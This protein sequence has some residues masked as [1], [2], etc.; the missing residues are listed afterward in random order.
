[1]GFLMSEKEE[2]VHRVL[3]DAINEGVILLTREGKV[4]FCN[5]L[6]A[7]MV[8]TPSDEIINSDFKQFFPT[9][10]HMV[11]EE[12]LN[13][14]K[15]VGNKEQFTLLPHDGS[16]LA[17]ELSI[18]SIAIDYEETFF[19]VITDLAER[20]KQE[21]ALWESERRFRLL[22]D[23]AKDYA[24]I[25]LDADGR[26][27]HWN[28]GA[29]RLNGYTAD[30]ML[31]ESFERFYLPEDIELEI[32][33]MALE[34]AR[35][36]GRY[37]CEG[38]RVRKDGS[39][40]WASLVLTAL[41]DNSGNLI[42]FSKLVRD[43]TVQKRLMED[44]RKN[45]RELDELQRLS[46][47]G[48][49]E[50]DP[51][52]DKAVWS[53]E[54]FHIMN[55]DPSQPPYTRKDASSLFTPVTLARFEKALQETLQTGKNFKVDVEI[56]QAAP[57]SRWLNLQGEV[58]QKDPNGKITLLRGTAQNITEQ[59][60]LEKKLSDSEQFIHEVLD[61]ITAHICVV[62]ETGGIIAT[63]EA[64][65]AFARENN[66]ATT[67]EGENYLE[68]CDRAQGMD[69]PDAEA[70]AAGLR[71][72]LKGEKRLY[73]Q[74]YSCHSPTEKRWFNGYA[75]R[76]SSGG[77]TRV[78]ISHENITA[79]KKVEALRAGES[80][81][82]ELVA[83]RA[84]L[85]EVLTSL[86]KMIEAQAIEVICSVMLADE[87]EKQL[88]LVAGPNLPESYKRSIAL[89]AIGPDIGSCG[90]AAFRKEPVIVTDI[91]VDPL[92]SNY[93]HLLDGFNLRA[94][95]SFPILSQEGKVLG[96]FGVYS[97]TPRAPGAEELQF[98]NVATHV[99]KIAITQQLAEE[100]LRQSEQR[101]RN[102]FAGAAVGQAL[103][104][105]D[106]HYKETNAAYAKISGYSTEELTHMD[107]RS[108]THAEDLPNCNELFG[109]MGAGEV[110][111]FVA[112]K[113]L[114]TKSGMYIWTQ[115]SVSVLTDAQGHPA[116]VLLITENISKRKQAE[117]AL[118]RSEQE[119]RQ[120]IKSAPVAI[121][122]FDRQM[123]YLA[124]SAR[125]LEFH[126]LKGNVIGRCHYDTSPGIKESWKQTHRRSL[127]GAVE[128]CEEDTFIHPNGVVEYM[129]WEVQP[130]RNIEGEIAGII[131]FLQ[132]ITQS[133]MAQ[134]ELRR[135]EERFRNMADLVPGVIFTCSPTGGIEYF[136]RWFY[137]YAGLPESSMGG[138][139]WI[140]LVHPDDKPFI[141][142]QHAKNIQSGEPYQMHFRLRSGSG[143]FR[144]FLT[145]TRP[146]HD[147]EGNIVQWQG[148]GTDIEEQKRIEQVLEQRVAQRTAKLQ[149]TVSELEQYSYSITHDLRAPLRAIQGFAN[150]IKED[151]GTQIP[152][153]A[154][155]NLKNIMSSA[156][157]MENLIRD[158]LNYGKLLL[159]D[160]PVEPINITD[161]TLDIIQSYPVLQ[162]PR[163]KIQ[164]EG[165]IP[166]V[167]GNPAGLAQSV[168]NLLRNAVKFVAPGVTPSV[169]IWSEPKNNFVR[170]WFEDNGIGIAPEAQE[171]IFDMFQQV[172]KQYEGTGI[173]LTIVRKAVERMG[174]KVGVESEIGKGSRFWIDLIAAKESR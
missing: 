139:Q 142:E 94:S 48:S 117:E 45:A 96:T 143:E 32:P 53:Q 86:V 88:R 166:L 113:R 84:P 1:M 59:K 30:E 104:D 93:H 118:Q 153:P 4:S 126:G 58:A 135:S 74:E 149:E 21:S 66:M 148:I 102:A 19:T 163:A 133:K 27:T 56:A 35:V 127:A 37:E 107:I 100:K 43:I 119:L 73:A 115:N 85:E 36:E 12:F 172:S 54:L 40:F 33:H 39:R 164:F 13:K 70:F 69:R 17:V 155:E 7:E 171:H 130:W 162:I 167:M 26:I 89:F 97:P 151:Y 15:R 34:K 20:K 138:S 23:E 57:A 174:G 134:E 65:R 157:R 16:P 14:A 52:M 64:W 125:W 29:Q 110:S 156:E 159:G 25:L 170:I 123:R 106:G 22:A 105:L 158:S 9:Y 165:D 63:N 152:P 150:I 55:R 91:L 131:I 112:Q 31:G 24:I 6:F 76:F 141:V 42:G 75:T 122:I 83:N 78:V 68:V 99:A 10:E 136:N 114:R 116:N 46:K 124:A 168:S 77:P 109:K 147:S 169:R 81:V 72:V 121:A 18:R 61:T 111:N 129:T 98:I 41:H 137:D 2:F 79:T 87:D 38:W 120:F 28:A 103:L 90:A 154:R 161:L 146:I 92:W 132:D 44:L 128:R 145:R 95:W 60:R 144:W 5:K 11:L 101:F 49:W 50:W 160:V 108:I 67:F 173:G 82:L 8:K 80:Q 47:I 140:N 62:D 51:E 3:L 71:K